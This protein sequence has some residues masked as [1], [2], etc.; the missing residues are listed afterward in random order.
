MSR[1]ALN[2]P[3]YAHTQQHNSDFSISSITIISQ[4]KDLKEQTKR[5]TFY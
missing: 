2:H 4:I 1:A 5:T 3:I